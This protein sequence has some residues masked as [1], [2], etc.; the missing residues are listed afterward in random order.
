MWLR[1]VCDYSYLFEGHKTRNITR[2]CDRYFVTLPQ[3]RIA[4]AHLTFAAEFTVRLTREA[5]QGF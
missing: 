1:G 3:S 5:L 2:T 4:L